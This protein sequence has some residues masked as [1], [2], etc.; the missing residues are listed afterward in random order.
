MSLKACLDPNAS[1]Y[2]FCAN[3]E[4]NPEAPIH[5]PNICEYAPGMDMDEEAMAESIGSTNY[6]THEEADIRGSIPTT[7]RE[8]NRSAYIEGQRNQ[9]S[10][11]PLL[12]LGILA[13]IFMS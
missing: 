5:D 6:T 3:G 8:R 4:Y 9:E 2:G 12:G 1:N 10:N 7:D 13:Y 11:A